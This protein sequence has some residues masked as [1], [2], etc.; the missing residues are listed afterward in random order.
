MW[1]ADRAVQECRCGQ[2]FNFINRKHHCRMCGNIFCSTC[3][4]YS[5]IPSF[6]NT[7]YVGKHRV[8]QDCSQR[9][10]DIWGVESLIRVFAL[11][12][13]WVPL[14]PISRKW[15]RAYQEVMQVRDHCTR[16][17]LHANYSNVE[18]SILVETKNIRRVLFGY[19]PPDVQVLQ[20]VELLNSHCAPRLIRTK[21]VQEQM[22]RVSTE[23]IILFMPWWHRVIP[24]VLSRADRRVVYA[25][26]F[27]NGGKSDR[28]QGIRKKLISGEHAAD[29]RATLSMMQAVERNIVRSV[30][31]KPGRLPYNPDVVV[32]AVKDVVRFRSASAPHALTLETSA[33]DIR[34][35]I[36][37]TDVRKDRCTMVICK[38]LERMGIRCV[39]YPVL[40]TPTGGWIQMLPAKT[41]YELGSNLSMHIFNEY[42][43]TPPKETREKFR[44]SVVGSCILSH[45]I[46]VG[47]RHLQN[48]VCHN[49]EIV[50][51]DFSY[52]LGHDPKLPQ[53]LRVTT[54]MIEMMGGKDST[55]YKSFLEE[56]ENAFRKISK[57]GS[58]W[59][60]LL[61]NVAHEE[62]YDLVTV[63][64]HVERQINTFPED[65]VDIVK[66]HSDT[67]MHTITDFV[68]GI[69]QMKL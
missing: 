46:G 6:T 19:P 17:M 2:K 27:A 43:D 21:W 48:I 18:R 44:K 49:G 55:C 37:S 41:L 30:A 68:H 4:G 32:R 65:V 29:I 33:G 10:S 14:V 20:L 31:F 5:N 34:I 12:L 60:A 59:C 22:S 57:Y 23:D 58:M 66:N 42:P 54:P 28:A 69:F 63:R 15:N 16:K 64:K 47:D 13:H 1:V 36:K 25:L 11:L 52:M 40:V 45:L 39:S 26:Y 3:L 62:L 8:C 24:H 67:W 61:E 7:N 53:P 38:V 35:L 56:T 50:H 51:I 9:C